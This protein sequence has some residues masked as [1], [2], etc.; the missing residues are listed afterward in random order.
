M[1]IHADDAGSEEKEVRPLSWIEPNRRNDVH[2]VPGVRQ[3]AM[4]H[5]ATSAGRTG[6]IAEAQLHRRLEPVAPPL[7]RREE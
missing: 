1:V 3:N 4:N 7:P 5:V 2:H 6:V